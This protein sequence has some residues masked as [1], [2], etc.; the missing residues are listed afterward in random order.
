M[1]SFLLPKETGF[2]DLFDQH[3]SLI[4]K[5]T[6]AFFSIWSSDQPIYSVVE[7]IKALEHEADITTHKTIELL[8]KTFI[9]PL[10]RD[11]IFRLISRMDDVI[12]HIEAAADC[13]ILYKITALPS[14]AKEMVKVLDECAKE[15]QFAVKGLHK[16]D[17][18]ASIRKRC[19]QIKHLE[20][21][22]DSILRQAI[23]KLFDEE[24]D[25]RLLIKWKEIYEHLEEAVDRC[26]DVSNI[27]EGV[28]LES[29]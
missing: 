10:E 4:E 2:F 9:T 12:D 11:D 13:L 28:I 23:G 5:S 22:A 18:Q 26:E 29:M 1:F 19:Y 21:E 3:A 20:N 24:P 14:S 15:L 16:M 25:T 17:N 27:I 7:T 6:E 8:H